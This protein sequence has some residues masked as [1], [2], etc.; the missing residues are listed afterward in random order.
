ME[1]FFI[2]IDIGGTNIRIASSNNLGN[3]VNYYEENS[4]GTADEVILRISL[5]IKKILEEIPNIK[6]VGI[7]IAGQIERES[8]MVISSPNLNWKNIPLKKHLEDSIRLPVYIINDVNAITYGE[9]KSGAGRG[10]NNLLCIYVGTG[11]GSGLVINDKL[12]DGCSNTAGEIGHI[13]IVS[14]GRKC[15]CGNAGCFEAYAGGW[16]I[17]ERIQEMALKD[18]E[19]F[20]NIIGQ[21]GGIDKINARSI[22]KAY[23]LNDK[24]AKEAVS[25]EGKY[26]SDGIISAVNLLNPCMV[27]LGGG[28]IDGIPD[29]LPI[30]KAEVKKRAL[31]TAT[32]P[33][34]IV[35][36]QLGG[37]AGVIG[38]AEYAKSSI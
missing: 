37:K 6:A 10:V 35:K 2:G 3:I 17:A 21:A 31:K 20:K 23:I 26:L 28:I 8:G 16:G 38:A 34:Q 1:Y 13:V 32:S 7:G 4:N 5:H 29:L 18:N 9:W 27:I 15:H 22:S 12:I 11:I 14:G 30:V 25:E 24:A 33:L 19:K 36:S